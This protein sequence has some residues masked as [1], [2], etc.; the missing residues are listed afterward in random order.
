MATM[1]RDDLGQ[2]LQT[3]RGA[4]WQESLNGD[5]Y[6]LLLRDFTDLTDA[7]SSPEDRPVTSGDDPAV[8]RSALGAWL[9]RDP[10]VARHVLADVRFGFRRPDGAKAH[11]QI[12]PATRSRL[13]VERPE[14][15]RMIEAARPVLGAEAV[16]AHRPA[17]RAHAEDLLREADFTAFDLVTDYANPLARRVLSSVLGADAVIGEHWAG[18][19]LVP[20]GT[21]TPQRLADAVALSKAL[22]HVEAAFAETDADPDVLAFRMAASVLFAATAPNVIARAAAD[23]GPVDAV[24]H[25]HP[26]L[27]LLS[28]VA[29]TEVDL[30]GTTVGA[31]EQ[32]V[33]LVADAQAHGP[34][35]DADPQYGLVLPLVRLTAEVAT[36][37]LRAGRNVETGKPLR[38]LRS[39]VT[40]TLLRLP[41]TAR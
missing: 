33:V 31:G 36:E 16:P 39:P 9:I 38:R 11:L 17:I 19:G 14:L 2:R 4:I 29:H 24:L 13:N 6:A 21:A 8:T 25:A 10:A 34:V 30:A 37:T 18:L 12:L 41:V 3:I 15:T 1:T 26:P 7:T 35:L 40:G 32:V 22:K 20:D 28:R 23:G 27:R 5:R